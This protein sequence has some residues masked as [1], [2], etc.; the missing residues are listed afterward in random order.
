[1]Y[2]SVR[3]TR[4]P[5]VP[6]CAVFHTKRRVYPDWDKE[7]G[8]LFSMS[9]CESTAAI[10]SI[11][12]RLVFVSVVICGRLRVRTQRP[13]PCGMFVNVLLSS[14]FHALQGSPYVDYKSPPTTY[15]LP[16]TYHELTSSSLSRHNNPFGSSYLSSQFI[17]KHRSSRRYRQSRGPYVRPLQGGGT[18]WYP[19]KGLR[20]FVFRHHT[21]FQPTRKGSPTL[22]QCSQSMQFLYNTWP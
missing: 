14:T 1:M 12:C 13:R 16:N 8:H 9:Y 7:P 15:N 11:C 21:E 10:C 3:V 20:L 5:C 2:L 18:M 17:S 4:H 6:L 22:A 19:S